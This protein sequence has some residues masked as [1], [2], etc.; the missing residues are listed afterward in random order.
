L[1]LEENEDD[2]SF[3]ENIFMFVVNRKMTITLAVD[4]FYL[5]D[6]EEN[7]RVARSRMKIEKQ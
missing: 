4:A 6:N 2:I 5:H 7:K 1:I 3:G